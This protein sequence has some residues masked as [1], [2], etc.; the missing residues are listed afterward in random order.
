MY[1]FPQKEDIGGRG[2]SNS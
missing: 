2:Q 1:V